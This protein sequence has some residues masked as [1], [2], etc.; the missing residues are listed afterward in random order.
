MSLHGETIMRRRREVVVSEINAV[1]RAQH[2]SEARSLN[3]SRVT[4]HS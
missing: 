2:C 4:R 3:V 1:I